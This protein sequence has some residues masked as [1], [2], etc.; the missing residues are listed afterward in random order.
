M[1]T[2]LFTW[3]VSVG[4]DRE[5]GPRRLNTNLLPVPGD[6]SSAQRFSNF[7]EQ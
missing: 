6:I 4:A 1:D 3:L 5:S 7:L 2:P